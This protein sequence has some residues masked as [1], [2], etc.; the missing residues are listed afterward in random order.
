MEP[1]EIIS[2]VF[3]LMYFCNCVNGLS[4]YFLFFFV[5]FNL[6]TILAYFAPVGCC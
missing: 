4:P 6:D 5:G 2:H 1:L 3:F